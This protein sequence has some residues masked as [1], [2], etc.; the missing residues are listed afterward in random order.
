[1]EGG[2]DVAAGVS[3]GALGGA[4]GG[5]PGPLADELVLGSHGVFGGAGPVC[6]VNITQERGEV[7][8]GVVDLLGNGPVPGS[9]HLVG[10]GLDVADGPAGEGEAVQGGEPAGG[11]SAEPVDPLL[12]PGD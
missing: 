6:G 8:G 5:L 1:M 10:G 3:V 9:E 11:N 7:G 4:E 2:G 12:Q